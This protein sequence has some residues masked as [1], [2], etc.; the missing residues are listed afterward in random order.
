MTSKYPEPPL[1]DEEVPSSDSYDRVISTMQSAM[2]VDKQNKKKH[3]N[4]TV[5][6]NDLILKGCAVLP[7]GSGPS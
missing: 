2:F 6:A 4:R 1:L 3:W 7:C 5:G